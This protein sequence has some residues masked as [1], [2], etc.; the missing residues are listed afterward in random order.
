MDYRGILETGRHIVGV[1]GVGRIHRNVVSADLGEGLVERDD[2]CL[3]LCGIDA[4]SRKKYFLLL[5][6]IHVRS[7]VAADRCG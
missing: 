5:C 7:M 1:Y 3:L 6:K 2:L 4:P